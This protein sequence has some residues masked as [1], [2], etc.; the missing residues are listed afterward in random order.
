MEI[1]LTDKGEQNY[2]LVI[3]TVYKF[4][5]QIKKEGPQ[6]YIYKEL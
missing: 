6:E 2:E 3:E 4:I 1:T 5:N